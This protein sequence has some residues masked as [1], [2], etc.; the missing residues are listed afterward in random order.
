[1]T[2]TTRPRH[3]AGYAPWSA[4]AWRNT[5]FVTA[6]VPVQLVAV[7]VIAW[8]WLVWHPDSAAA[9]LL[10]L[11]VP[12]VVLPA[13]RRMLT[14][15]QRERFAA[16]LG[17]EVR[18][19][20]G[21]SL[22]SEAAWRQLG[23]HVLAG[24]VVAV[25][26]LATVLTWAAGAGL[27]G[28]HGYAWALPRTSPVSEAHVFRNSVLTITGLLLLCT[29]P[30]MAGAVAK[31]D[32]R[33]AALLLGPS[34]SRELERR[35]EDLTES[36]A[37]V[38]DAAD[39]ER[40][41]IERDLHDGAQQRLVSLALNLGLA[42]ETLKDVP[43]DAMQVIVE[44]HEEAKEAL[45]ELRNLVRGL[46]PA[47]LEDRGLDAALSGI[48]ARSPLLVRLRVDVPVRASPT[49]EAVA[50]FVASEALTNVNRHAGASGVEMSVERIGDVLKVV[51]TD[52]G[53]G[54]ADPSLGTGLAGLAKRARSV[55]GTF[56]IVSPDG[57]PTTI[58]VELP[59]ES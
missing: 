11:V 44:A 28:V 36:R 41:R 51:V 7:L 4:W 25:G 23:Y 15:M 2:L 17:V 56:R 12:V 26:A 22:P 1:M 45:T 18:R 30:L 21:A 48:A 50:Y 29:A 3:V 14:A 32:T 58:T 34:R 9:V 33:A 39:T 57:G 43:D 59:C 38:V 6:G 20:P 42:R 10:P 46:H 27:A 31:L 13:A 47:V 19:A 24:P 40:R 54:G 35:V 8:P 49:V 5:T 55:D 52:D 53:V 16:L 37:G